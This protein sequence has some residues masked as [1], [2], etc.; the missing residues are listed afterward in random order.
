[1]FVLFHAKEFPRFYLS[2][3]IFKIMERNAN[4]GD[5]KHIPNFGER[6]LESG[7]I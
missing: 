3:N 7:N 1:M 2:R 4:G 6:R 5:K